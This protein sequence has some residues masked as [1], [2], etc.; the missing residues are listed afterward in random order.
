MLSKFFIERPIFANVIAIVTM[1]LGIVSLW[2]SADRAV[3]ADHAAHGPRDR[4]LSRRQ[5]RGRGQHRRRADRAAGQRRREHA[6]HVVDFVE[7]RQLFAHGHVRHRHQSRHGPGAG[8]EP[9]GDRRAAGAGGSP[10]AGRHRQE[11][12]D[13]HHSRRLAHLARQTLRRSVS[14]ELCHAA[15][16]RR[17]EPRAGRRRRDCLRHGQL[18]HA[19]LARSRRSSKPADSRPQDV[20]RS[21]HEQNVQVAAGQIGQPPLP[22]RQR[23]RVSIHG[24]DAGPAAATSSSSRTSSSRPVDGSQI[25]RLE[26]RG[27][28]SSS[29][30]R[31][32]TSSISS[33]ASRPPTSASSSCRAATRWTSP[34][35][36]AR[37]WSG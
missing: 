26:R 34:T 23:R 9:R 16:P 27:H 6:L 12:I 13:E 7:R 2:Q 30:P 15:T 4:Q 36:S 28:A 25:T 17:A 32:T 11:A 20:V 21:I 5:C 18:Q 24:D 31:P 22:S 37:P 35:T 14:G 29:G 19:D 33:K 8:A 3:S 1:L 10:P